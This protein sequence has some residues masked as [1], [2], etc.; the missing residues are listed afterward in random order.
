MD[1]SNEKY[2]DFDQRAWWL[3]QNSESEKKQADDFGSSLKVI[4]LVSDNEETVNSTQVDGG[5]DVN[6]RLIAVA[7]TI[8]IISHCSCS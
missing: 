4:T 2:E 8:E 1:T 6:R 3:H 5:T 7:E